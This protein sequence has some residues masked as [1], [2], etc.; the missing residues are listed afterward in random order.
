MMAMIVI[1][2]LCWLP[3]HCVTVLGDL[4]P[5]I[6]NF[7]DIQLVWIVCHW[8]AVSSC[9]WNPIVYYWTNDTLRAGF[10]YAVGVWC[11]CV[12]R[13]ADAP[14][15]CRRQ[16]VYRCPLRDGD[17]EVERA[18]SFV[19][20]ARLHYR[21]C[22]T[23]SNSHRSNDVELHHLRTSVSANRPGRLSVSDRRAA[24]RTY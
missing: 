8:L 23:S 16:V 17:K 6:W 20:A 19:Q 1:Y 7:D 3:L 9:C 11:P 24:V 2:A 10:M 21:S 5:S 4:H 15:V 13:A 14:T 22:R 18:A 12:H